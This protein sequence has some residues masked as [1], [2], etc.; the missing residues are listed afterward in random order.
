MSINAFIK[1]IQK[2]FVTTAIPCDSVLRFW[3]MRLGKVNL[4]LCAC[5]AWAWTRTTGNG[6]HSG[7]RFLSAS[8]LK[9]AE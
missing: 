1:N 6:G 5:P 7:R 2:N 3:T 9:I 4:G 8:L